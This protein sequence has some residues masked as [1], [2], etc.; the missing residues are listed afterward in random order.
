MNEN[1]LI[2]FLKNLLA[3]EELNKLREQ[4]RQLETEIESFKLL[5]NE[6]FND[7]DS[8]TK[9]K[10]T[11]LKKVKKELD[12]LT[13]EYEKVVNELFK[14]SVPKLNEYVFFDDWKEQKKYYSFRGSS[15]QAHTHWENFLKNNDLILKY[16][17]FLKD[18]LKFLTGYTS[19]KN[20]DEL[21]YKLVLSL[22]KYIDGLK[23]SYQS[24]KQLFSKIEYWMSPSEAFDYYVTKRIAGDCD[25]TMTFMYANLMTALLHYGFED[26]V[27]RLKGRII[28]ILGAGGHAVLTWLKADDKTNVIGWMNIETTYGENAWR[29]MW[30][31]NNLIEDNWLITT[32]FIF[33]EVTEYVR[34]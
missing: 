22:H 16:N 25:D 31:N 6:L 17:N 7:S 26:D 13:K 32:R 8:Y 19:F 10:E 29:K 21:V 5:F 33:D 18:E 15:K 11:E 30:D 1:K 27:W 20:A 28:D 23:I 9:Q 34:K 3:G 24:D 14:Y 4:V 12:N 2:N